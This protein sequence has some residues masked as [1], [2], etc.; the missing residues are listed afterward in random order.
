MYYVV[1]ACTAVAQINS[2]SVHRSFVLISVIYFVRHKGG[3]LCLFELEK[4]CWV[5]FTST[6]FCW[7]D[8]LCCIFKYE[9]YCYTLV[10]YKGCFLFSVTFCGRLESAQI[11]L[12]LP[13]GVIISMPVDRQNPYHCVGLHQF[14]FC[15]VY[16]F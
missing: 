14:N 11:A 8:L 1:L 6:A 4:T 16:I 15:T 5:F 10:L 13:K 12:L 3:D 7:T 2:W 9:L